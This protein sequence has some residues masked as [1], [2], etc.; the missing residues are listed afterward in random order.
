MAWIITDAVA[1]SQPIATTSTV[2]NHPVGKIVTAKDPTLGEGEFI[3]LKGVANTVVG[4]VVTYVAS[5]GVTVLSTTSGVVNGGAPLAVAMSANVASQWG[6]YQISGDATI[7]KTA[8]K[9]DPAGTT[10]VYLS[11]TS[12]RVMQTSVAGRQV[13][14]ARWI[15]ATTVT[16]TTSTAIATLNRA[17]QQGAIT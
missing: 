7:K 4:L 12:G 13:I 8:V 1:G 6:W 14:G 17:H 10:K 3:Y 16:S 9:V 11:A 2:Q 5:T 15:T